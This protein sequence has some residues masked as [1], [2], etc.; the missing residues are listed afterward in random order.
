MSRVEEES[1]DPVRVSGLG[2]LHVLPD[3]VFKRILFLLIRT[4]WRS[5]NLWMRVS[6]AFYQVPRSLTFDFDFVFFLMMLLLCPCPSPPILSI[7]PINREARV[8]GISMEQT[9]S[10]SRPR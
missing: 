1:T 3:R 2:A 8:M 4:N 10:V 9:H 6:C 7:S 5:L